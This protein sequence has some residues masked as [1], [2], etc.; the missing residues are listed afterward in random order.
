ME[1]LQSAVSQPDL[2]GCRY[3]LVQE[4]GR[5]GMGIVYAARDHQLDRLVALK[6]LAL[7]LESEEASRRLIGEARLIARLEHPGIVPVYDAGLLPDGRF[8]YAMRLVSGRRLDHYAREERSLSARL[9]VFRKLC[10]A[11]AYA[12]SH[13]IVHRDL[14]PRNIMIGP[15]GEVLILDW[16]IARTPEEPERPGLVA[17][18]PRFM[19]PEQASGEPAS[20]AA[21]IYALGA[22]LRVLL[23]EYRS[24]PLESI[25]RQAMATDPEKRYESALDLAADA[26][27]F[28]D[29]S[30]VSAHAESWAERFGRFW[31][32]N[33]T[34]L[35]LLIA[36]VTVRL[37]LYLF[38]RL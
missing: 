13:D 34:L 31:R 23:G 22:I 11:V 16:G 5:G 37:L 33:R 6:V 35:I 38:S 26:G 24:R 20:P 4:L 3:T 19:A 1:R 18:T 25:A 30:A 32:R 27:R 12:H 15:F 14:N 10:E 21:D 17:G 7:P 8:F 29:D 9:A 28:L 36:Y 2:G